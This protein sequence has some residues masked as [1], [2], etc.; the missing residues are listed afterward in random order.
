[1]TLNSLTPPDARG[2][3]CVQVHA[4]LVKSYELCKVMSYRWNE[5]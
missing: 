5:E 3:G 4:E 2:R 1:M